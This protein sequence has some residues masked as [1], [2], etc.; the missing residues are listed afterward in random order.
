MVFLTPSRKVLGYYLKMC[1]GVTL[2]LLFN[3][4]V[5]I[6]YWSA[7]AAS[8]HVLSNLLFT[9]SSAA[10]YN[11][12]TSDNN[13]MTIWYNLCLQMMTHICMMTMPDVLALGP[14]GMTNLHMKAILKTS[15]WV[16]MQVNL[17][18][19]VRFRMAGLYIC[20][21]INVLWYVGTKIIQNLCENVICT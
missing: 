21:I 4:A 17:F 18:H 20:H 15:W 2:H 16:P 8:F 13:K 9:N 14:I 12:F 6:K 3:D 7:M 10:G 19:L 1:H 5:S 11:I